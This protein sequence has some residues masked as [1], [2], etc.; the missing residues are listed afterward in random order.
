VPPRLRHQPFGIE[1]DRDGAD[2]FAGGRIDHRHAGLDLELLGG[3]VLLDIVDED[4]ARTLGE[5]VLVFRLVALPIVAGDVADADIEA[6]VVHQDDFGHH[7]AGTVAPALGLGG[8]RASHHLVDQRMRGRADLGAPLLVERVDLGL[9]IA[10]AGGIGGI[11]GSNH[12]SVCDP[13]G[14]L[15]LG[16]VLGLRLDLGIIG[17]DGGG[18]GDGKSRSGGP[19]KK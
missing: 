4:S 11:D 15:P 2:R 1:T 19:E 13:F 5:G 9:V 16:I 12:V 6:L 14:D 10:G 17:Q 7:A 18:N 3:A 8:C